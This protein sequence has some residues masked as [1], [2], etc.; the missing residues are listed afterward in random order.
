[1]LV[2]ARRRSREEPLQ[3]GLFGPDALFGFSWQLALHGDPLSD[4]EMDDLARAATPIIKMRDN[5]TVVD[6]RCSSGPASG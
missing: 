3:T 1:M 6:P 5:W 2:R 4:E